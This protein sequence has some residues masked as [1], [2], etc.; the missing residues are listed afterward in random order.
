MSVKSRSKRENIIVQKQ[1]KIS[2]AKQKVVESPIQSTYSMGLDG[3]AREIARLRRSGRDGGDG[4]D[5]RRSGR[6]G[7]VCIIR[8]V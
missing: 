6:D 4:G 7:T 5:G 1:A 2:Q 8:I 3:T